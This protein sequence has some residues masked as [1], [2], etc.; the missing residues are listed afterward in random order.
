M[1]KTNTKQKGITLVA[2]IITI[3]VMLILIGVS[4]NIVLNNGLLKLA[5]NAKQKTEQAKEEEIN[6]NPIGRYLKSDPTLIPC[7]IEITTYIYPIGADGKMNMEAV[8]VFKHTYSDYIAGKKIALK[9]P[10]AS[11]SFGKFRIYA[12]AQEIEKNSG[13][14]SVI[15]TAD[16]SNIT[17]Q[18]FETAPF[19]LVSFEN[20]PE[21]GLKYVDSSIGTHALNKII[22]DKRYVLYNTGYIPSSLNLFTSAGVSY[23][24]EILPEFPDL[25]GNLIVNGNIIE[26]DYISFP[27]TLYRHCMVRFLSDLDNALPYFQDNRLGEK[28]AV[29]RVCQIYDKERVLLKQTNVTEV[30]G[31][32]SCLS[33]FNLRTEWNQ[34]E[35]QKIN[36]NNCGI[37]FGDDYSVNYAD[38]YITITDDKI[39]IDIPE[40]NDDITICMFSDIQFKQ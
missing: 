1:K 30:V 17:L 7:D 37:Y 13:G 11:L 40:I 3:I 27:I 25:P 23:K 31:S 33:G 16:P 9:I 12:I 6:T 14:A 38:K 22:E 35:N 28:T 15:D 18:N 21:F 34:K 2:L 32:G 4:V 20:K 36:L 26:G 24:V 8:A 19:Y 5:V 10:K 29:S 39:I